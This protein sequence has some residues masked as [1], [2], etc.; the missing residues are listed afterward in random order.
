M[1][2]RAAVLE[3]FGQPLTVQEVELAGDEDEVNPVRYRVVVNH[4]VPAP[5]EVL[6]A[7]FEVVAPAAQV[8]VR[9][10]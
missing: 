9:H 4:V 2:M 7:L 6:R 5:E 10:V 1:R 8:D 3:E